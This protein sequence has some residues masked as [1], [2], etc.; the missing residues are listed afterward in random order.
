MSSEQPG[1]GG[2]DYSNVVIV[3]RVIS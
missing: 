1:T 3:Y 2:G